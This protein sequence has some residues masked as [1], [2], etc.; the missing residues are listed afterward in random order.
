MVTATKI[1][2]LTGLLI[3]PFEREIAACE[4][5]SNVAVWRETAA[6]Q[7]RANPSFL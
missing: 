6:T 1:E 3:D 5:E 7:P 4:V 2:M